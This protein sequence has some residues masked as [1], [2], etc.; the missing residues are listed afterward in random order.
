MKVTIETNEEKEQ[1]IT[2]PCLMQSSTDKS[3][4]VLRLSE[5]INGSFQG[6]VVSSGDMQYKVGSN[7]LDWCYPHFNPLPKGTKVILEN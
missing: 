3:F 7:E 2:F 1:E 4:I 5:I 6:V